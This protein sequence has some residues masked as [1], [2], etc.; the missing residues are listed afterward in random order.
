MNEL[1]DIVHG[2]MNH[3]EHKR[4]VTAKTLKNYR[5]TCQSFLNWAATE[6]RKLDSDSLQDY[7]GRYDH[8]PS[9]NVQ[10]V[11]LCGLAKFA[12][13]PVEVT[14]AKE[15]L[16]EVLALS[17]KQVMALVEAAFDISEDLGNSTQF[18]AETGLRFDEFMRASVKDVRVEK[19]VRV[20]AVIGKGRKF[21]RVPLTEAA[22]KA[23]VALPPRTA[24][25]EKHLRQGLAQAGEEAD[26]DFHVHPHLLRASFISILLN[27]RH[28]EAIHV[29]QLVGHANINTMLKHY[30]QVSM[31]KLGGILVRH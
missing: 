19:N 22:Y 6:G 14:R 10:L 23:L 7:V 2:Y 30:A 27:E 1:N 20:L 5:S 24:M 11:R 26:I 4:R 13:V 31:E 16:P 3:L 21:R 12:K 17:S 9:A 28:V 29:A 25:F 18:L 8:A 15:E